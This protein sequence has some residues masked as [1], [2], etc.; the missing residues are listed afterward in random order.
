[1]IL[2]A[3]PY[4]LTVPTAPRGLVEPRMPN[5]SPAEPLTLATL[6]IVSPDSE[7]AQRLALSLIDEPY[8]IFVAGSIVDAK[9]ELRVRAM[10]VVMVDEQL[11]AGLD[12]ALFGYLHARQPAIIRILLG[13][14]EIVGNARRAARTG[15]A[16]HCVP[17]GC[18]PGEL[19]LLLYN[20]LVQRSFLPPESEGILPLPSLLPP[21][22]S[23]MPSRAPGVG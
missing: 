11:E 23:V 3:R 14:E 5:H 7:Q 15:S 13:R 1:M 22:S 20:T 17:I 2:R 12:G 18:D 9:A 6:L 19:A 10:D 21:S 8:E 4:P 16:H